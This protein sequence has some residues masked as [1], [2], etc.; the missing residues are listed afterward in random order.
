MLSLSSMPIKK[1]LIIIQFKI[2]NMLFSFLHPGQGCLLQT[3]HLK[4][5][6]KNKL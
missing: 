3:W 2:S 1:V 4:Q 5:L 6:S